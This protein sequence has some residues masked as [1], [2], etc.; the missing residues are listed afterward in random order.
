MGIFAR[1]FGS[2]EDALKQEL[3]SVYGGPDESFDDSTAWGVESQE[4][5]SSDLSL[6]RA[7][8]FQ[9]EDWDSDYD[10]ETD[11]EDE[12]WDRPFGE[13]PSSFKESF[14]LVGLKEAKQALSKREE[15]RYAPV[16]FDSATCFSTGIRGSEFYREILKTKRLGQVELELVPEPSNPHDCFAVAVDLDGD[17]I[18]YVGSKVANGLQW[19]IRALNSVGVRCLTIGSIGGVKEVKGKE[20][21]VVGWNGENWIVLPT[22]K[23]LDQVIERYGRIKLPSSFY[24]RLSSG[25][26]DQIRKD[27]FH[28][29]SDTAELLLL[30]RSEA[31]Y[32]FP[33]EDSVEG[34]PPVWGR[35]LQKV[36]LAYREQERVSREKRNEA[37]EDMFNRGM[38]KNDIAEQV[39]LAA[40]TVGEILR[41]KRKSST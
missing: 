30:Y 14:I 18:G 21:N 36:R 40:S 29:T 41:K 33:L 39:G 8:D 37:I 26:K 34:F 27:R 13:Y 38:S 6:V 23:T 28:L 32:L 12:K 35:T 15:D 5:Q 22:F 16:D 20:G 11:L 10:S 19:Y 4:V 9:V 1:I 2:K 17:R 7:A 25:V 3:P 31:P 24:E